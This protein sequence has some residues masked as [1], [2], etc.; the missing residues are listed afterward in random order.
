MY[1]VLIVD[2]EPMA[3]EAIK[4]AADWEELDLFICGECT[5]GKDAL[6]LAR[7]MRPDLIITDVEMPIM[8]GIELVRRVASDV[9]PDIKFIIV[10]GYDQ[11]EYAKSAMQL[12]VQHY[13][14][15]PVFKDEFSEVLLKILPSIE[16]SKRLKTICSVSTELDIGILFE[17]FLAGKISEQDLKNVLGH[18]TIKEDTVWSFASIDTIHKYYE[19]DA[20]KDDYIGFKVF[21]TIKDSL[22]AEGLRDTFIYPVFVNKNIN[23]FVLCSREGN[24]SIC[25]LS[26][27]LCSILKKIYNNGFYLA[28]GNQVKDIELL[29]KSMKEAE[30]AIGY[31]FYAPPGSI[32]QYK[33]YE[34]YS[35]SYSFENNEYMEYI[36]ELQNSF[37]N[38]DIDRILKAMDSIFKVFKGEHIAY[39]M[40]KMYL[41]SIIYKSLSILTAMGENIDNV[42]FISDI[43]MLISS[44]KTIDEIELKIKNYCIDFCK[45][46]QEVKNRFKMAD[47]IKVEQYINENYKTNLTI[48]E[49]SSKLHLHPTYLGSQISKWFGCSFNDYLHSLRMKEAESL[50]KNTNK[51]VHDIAEYLGYTSYGNFLEQFTKTFSIKPSEYKSKF[52]NNN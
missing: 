22:L 31:R 2:D 41:N 8:N 20:D 30:K 37:E 27:S 38:I 16:Q 46:A 26:Q 42:P 33:D 21:D 51:K 25:K 6:K 19:N 45:H 49:I 47:K 32:L 40:I 48:K 34:N 52:K 39:E 12:G 35:L 13:I 28:M 29:G 5:N 17:K 15:K 3:I 10:S 4:L 23:G 11:F 50:I 7:E 1:K 18:E 14:L 36:E 9:D 24:S 43:G 44:A